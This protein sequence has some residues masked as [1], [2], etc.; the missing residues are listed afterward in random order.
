MT[1]LAVILTLAA[2][3]AGLFIDVNL[4]TATLSVVLPL[5]TMGAFILE[6]VKRNKD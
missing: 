5:A 3:Y 6:A 4:N 1:I 2:W